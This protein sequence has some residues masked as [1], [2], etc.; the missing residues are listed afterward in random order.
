MPKKDRRV[1]AYIAK[2]A[3]F[4]KPILQHFRQVVHDTCPDVEEAIKW[5][6]VTFL[7]K[8]II[9]GV[10]AF[11]RHCR[12]GFWKHA[13]VVKNHPAGPEK[14]RKEM[15]RL[16]RVESLSDMPPDEIL[17]GFIQTAARL[18]EQGVKL[19]RT[20]SREKKEVAVPSDL[21]AALKKNR[22][23]LEAFEK[24]SPSHRREYVEWLSE[25]KRE[26]TRLKRLE[27]TIAWLAEG[28]PRNWK[29]MN[30]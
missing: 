27:T 9:C 19:T 11:Q 28:K 10:A 24:F 8:G 13:L 3:D 16:L 7:N 20:R 14:A 26:E 17:V 30:C 21:A 12:I 22:K 6:H 5:Q 25:A 4:A 1:N 29:Y 23:A 15:D 2:S 18:N